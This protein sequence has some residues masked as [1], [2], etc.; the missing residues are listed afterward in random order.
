MNQL[1]NQITAPVHPHGERKTVAASLLAAL[2]LAALMLASCMDETLVSTTYGEDTAT[3]DA[4]MYLS[5]NVPR[6]TFSLGSYA[7][8]ESEVETLDVMVFAKG[9][10]DP[11][12]YYVHAACKGTL[13][14]KN[15]NKFQ[16]VMPVGS[17]FIVHVFANCH[18]AMVARNFYNSRGREM[19]AML[20]DLAEGTNVNDDKVSSLP[21]HGYVTGV[22]IDKTKVNSKLDVPV[23]RSVAAV[24]VMTKATTGTNGSYTPGEVKGDDGKKNF[25]LR[26]LYVYFYPDSGRVAA[27]S[28]SYEALVSG[29]AD[30][31]RDVTKVSLPKNHSVSDTRMVPLDKDNP[32]PQP[33]RII[34]PTGVG[35][36][37]CLYLYEN[38]PYSDTG[39]DQPDADNPA[40]TSRIV[41]GGVYNEEKEADGVT[42]KVTYYR[43]DFADASNHLSEVLR[44]HKYTFSIESVSGTGYDTP[45]DA[46]TGVPINIY[47]KVIDWT[48]DLEHVDFDRQNRFYSETKNIVLPRNAN[49][50]RSITVESDVAVDNWELS[51]E[52]EANGAATLNGNALYNN[53][54]KVEKATDGKSLTFTVLKAYNDLAAGGSLDETLILKAK[55]LKI[56]YRITQVDKSPDDW[57]N[58]GDMNTDLDG[59]NKPI[60]VGL[61]FY[62]A[63]GNVVY[64]NGIYTFASEQGYYEGSVSHYRWNTLDPNAIKG[65]TTGVW[66]DA[67]DPCRKIDGGKWYTPKSDQW[68]LLMDAGSVQGTYTMKNGSNVYGL[69]FGTTKVPVQSEQDKYL[70]LPAAGRKYNKSWYDQG[71]LGAYWSSTPMSAGQSY[72]LIFNSAPLLEIYGDQVNAGLP[73]R[74]VRDK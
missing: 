9:K 59:I 38:K 48:D 44:N 45:D 70:F 25:E 42:P 68:K 24:Q 60:E 20:A 1:V 14:D 66:N 71:G 61:D 12:N 21:M 73:I 50:A 3:D 40:A 41:V 54:Y 51:F 18:D 57:G 15:D 43:V 6:T 2:L 8:K 11:K 13:T 36:L 63:K 30:Q 47:I 23:L 19:N 65:S 34:S 62:F 67:N 4:D 17:D 35:R 5:V 33:Y 56:T 53:R 58:G 10:A 29:D 69:Y 7:D 26:E 37:G 46:A 27:A 39:F 32:N 64:A 74:C 16:V 22:T 52:S 49:S 31:T 72:Y 28:E 55:E